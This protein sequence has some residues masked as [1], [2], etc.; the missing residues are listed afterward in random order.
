MKILKNNQK[1]PS[2]LCAL[3][4]EIWCRI[5]LELKIIGQ[6]DIWQSVTKPKWLQIPK[7]NK[8][9]SQKWPCDAVGLRK[10]CLSRESTHLVIKAYGCA[11]WTKVH[12]YASQNSSDFVSP[13]EH[14]K[15]EF[16]DLVDLS[17]NT[18]VG[19]SQII[20]FVWLDVLFAVHSYSKTQSML[21][22]LDMFIHLNVTQKL[23]WLLTLQ[24][25][26]FSWEWH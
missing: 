21:I 17:S 13:S 16:D 1:C 2:D 19:S 15:T 10:L 12:T 11:S 9:F 6:K 7:L 14:G 25:Y 5:K 22:W 20:V 4:C 24:N 3:V 23:V 18:T 8:T 26:N